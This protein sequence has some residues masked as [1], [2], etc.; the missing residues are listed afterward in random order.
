MA[1]PRTEG[2]SPTA[3]PP[4]SA[5]HTAPTSRASNHPLRHSVSDAVKTL[6]VRRSISAVHRCPK[7]V[8]SGCR[9][10]SPGRGVACRGRSDKPHLAADTTVQALFPFASLSFT[11]PGLKASPLEGASFLSVFR[12]AAKELR[13]LLIETGLALHLQTVL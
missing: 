4:W 5:G 11:C 9:W 12:G 8:R 7:N 3:S 2:R 6:C 10:K 13:C 1:T